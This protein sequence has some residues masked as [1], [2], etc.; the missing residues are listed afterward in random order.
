[1]NTATGLNFF[2]CDNT[3]MHLWLFQSYSWE[4]LFITCLWDQNPNTSILMSVEEFDYLVHLSN[5]FY[6]VRIFK[7]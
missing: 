6:S 7:D 5:P 3:D 1:M 2:F 4:H